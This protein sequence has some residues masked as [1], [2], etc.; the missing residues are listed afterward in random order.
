MVKISY[1]PMPKGEDINSLIQG[2]ERGVLKALLEKRVVLNEP[3][4]QREEA[5]KPQVSRSGKLI[6]SNPNLLTY[7][8]PPLLFSLIGGIS[9]TNIERLRVTLKVECPGGSRGRL[10]HS[11]DLYNDDQL[12]RYARKAA[13]RLDV[14]SGEM[15]T[16]LQKLVDQVEA[17]R[18]NQMRIQ[19]GGEKVELSEARKA[20]AIKYLK[21]KN[22]LRRTNADIEKTGVVGERV[23]RLLM[24]LCFTSRLRETPLHVIT[25]GGSGTGKTY[26]QERIGALMPD[27]EVIQ[28][29]ASTDNAFYY[30]KNGDLRHK[31]IL[32]EDLDGAEGVLYIL[33]ELM[34]KKWVSKLVVN[35]DASGKMETIRVEVHGPISLASTTTRD[36]LYEDNANRSIPI[37][38]DGG[39]EQARAIMDQQ[40]RMSAGLIHEKEQ[41]ELREFMKDVQRVLQPIKVRN[42][43]AEKLRIPE[44]CFKPL[45]TN[46]QYLHFIETVTFYHQYQRERKQCPTTGETYIE[47]A[48]ADIEAANALLKDVLLAKS[49]ELVS[50]ASRRFYERLKEWLGGENKSSFTT[51]EV[52]KGLR[53]APRTVYRYLS[54]LRSYGYVAIHGG[55]RYSGGLK[56]ELGDGGS[57]YAELK[58]NVN[59]V[60]DSLVKE[61][62]SKK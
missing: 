17:Y 32:I 12:E 23:N 34:S 59:T 1:V 51:G 25:M 22:L 38:P 27:E 50:R 49:D 7:E 13:D 11:F 9:M 53:L 52:R 56:Y 24:Y 29:T 62:K 61:L 40:R 3:E 10:R 42:P 55:N 60:L 48:L 4:K 8:Y 20:K 14:G 26:L 35:K 19:K 46:A 6:T 33:R 57:S 37:Y 47:T 36:R 2:H 54:E 31:L 39:V 58:E 45:R 18:L 21:A 5:P 30:I 41:E 44:E 16:A 43:Y 15:R 28:C